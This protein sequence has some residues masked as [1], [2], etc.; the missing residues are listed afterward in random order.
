[1]LTSRTDK[2][3]SREWQRRREVALKDSRGCPTTG[4]FTASDLN[5]TTEGNGINDPLYWK[6]ATQPADGFTVA[7]SSKIDVRDRPEAGGSD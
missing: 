1:M 3:L 7:K 4:M 5:I 2:E 6:V